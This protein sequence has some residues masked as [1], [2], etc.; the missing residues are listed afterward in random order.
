V[1]SEGS[2]RERD[3]ARYRRR[4]PIPAIIIVALLGVVAVVVWTK[5]ISKASDV[6]AAVACT[7]ATVAAAPTTTKAAK[8]KTKSAKPVSGTALPY[9]ALDKIS[10]EPAA[11]I[12][13]QVFNASTARGAAT[14]ASNQ[15]TQDGLQVAAPADDP[16]YPKQDMKCRG[17]IRFGANGESA[18]RTVSLLVPCTQLVRDNRQDATV[19]L[20][21]GADFTGVA[22]NNE[23]QQAIQQLA[24]W[25]AKHPTPQGGQQAQSSVLPKL[26]A[27]L[28]SKAHSDEC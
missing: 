26:N 2:T 21:I 3:T 20:A 19:D 9:N 16:L 22:P 11:S 6:D 4:K 14:Q 27:S 28:L 8:P 15:L 12:K 5:V 25:A 17:Q 23:A 13:V 24:A 18:A 1:V 7:P 10:P